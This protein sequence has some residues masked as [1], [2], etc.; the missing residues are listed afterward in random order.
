LRRLRCCALLFC[1]YGE[2]GR[3]ARPTYDAM[4]AAEALLDPVWRRR[5]AR[6]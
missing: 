4:D 3:E 6:S 5:A 2:G 1:G